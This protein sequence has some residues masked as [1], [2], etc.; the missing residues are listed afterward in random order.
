MGKDTCPFCAE[1]IAGG[2]TT[3]EAC[4]EHLVRAPSAAP[5]K[6][7][8]GL[9]LGIVVAVCFGGV[10]LIGVLATLL[11]P[12]LM[13]AKSKANRS[14]CVNNLRHVGLAM[15]QYAD[16]RRFYPH[17]GPTQA[18]DGDVTTSDTPKVARSL[19]WYGYH[20]RPDTFVCPESYDLAFGA[21]SP[22]APTAGVGSPRT[23]FW[24][25]QTIP[26]STRS[27]FVDGQPDPTLDTTDEL[28]YGWTRR[29][30]S[31]NV[32]GSTR[33]SAD[34]A[35]RS[36]PSADDVLAGNHAE[37]WNVGN[38]D[39]TVEWVT[40]ATTGDLT[41]TDASDREAG[42]LCIEDPSSP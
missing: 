2:A 13:K 20:D 11:M 23:W 8:T 28:S 18:L 24:Q 41:S 27:P 17:V 7:N 34:R 16:D 37:G 6:S 32:R 15:I 22:G 35:R 12:A 26:K 39:G 30:L 33:L 42:F 25:G 19:I 4:G 3:C 29:G 10:C 40:P 5:V 38:A 9:I 14:K 36:D 31:P 1:P 21:A